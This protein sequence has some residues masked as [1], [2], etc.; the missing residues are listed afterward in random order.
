MAE[1]T[2]TEI[3][4]APCPQ[5]NGERNCFIRGTHAVRWGHHSLPIY[6]SNTGQILE[7]CGCE[8]IFFRK[9]FW[10]SEDDSFGYDEAGNEVLRQN[11]KITYFPN[12][13]ARTRPEWLLH[14]K[15]ADDQLKRLL[16]DTYEALD[17][18]LLIFAAVGVR[19]CLDRA[20]ESFDIDPGDTFE[21]KLNAMFHQGRIGETEKQHLAVLIDAGNAAAHRGWVPSFEAVNT[22]IGT[23]EHLI[24]RHFIAAVDFVALKGQVPQK[25]P[26]PGRKRTP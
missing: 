3:T 19:T 20:S 4:K 13:P 8:E 21:G 10:F 7:C 18:G 9:S 1:T 17:A 24:E 22:M 2:T 16:D 25:Q 12:L 6:S 23:L 14:H 26:R 11:V 5:C 15:L